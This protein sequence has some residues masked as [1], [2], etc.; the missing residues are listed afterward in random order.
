MIKKADIVL[1]IA[2][3]V[4][5]LFVSWY[6]LFASQTGNEVVITADGE[7]FGIYSL[8]EEREIDVNRQGARP[9]RSAPRP[10]PWPPA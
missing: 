5:G 10:A 3:I 9:A 7:I 4:V 6:S 8:S 2:I 1:C